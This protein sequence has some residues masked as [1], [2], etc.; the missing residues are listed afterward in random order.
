MIMM[1][2]IRIRIKKMTTMK[3]QIKAVARI[4]CSGGVDFP[5]SLPSRFPS[6]R[7]PSLL[8]PIR[9]PLISSKSS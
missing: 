7:L 5:P 6:L 1:T 3:L 4:V 2:M 8:F 9:S